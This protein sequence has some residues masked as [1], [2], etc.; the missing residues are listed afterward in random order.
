MKCLRE[1]RRSYQSTVSDE[2]IAYNM[3]LSKQERMKNTE[4]E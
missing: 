3:Y 4:A 1:S 2:I